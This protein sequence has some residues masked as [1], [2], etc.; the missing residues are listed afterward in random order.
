MVDNVFCIK[1]GYKNGIWYRVLA[2]AKVRSMFVEM[3]GR[4]VL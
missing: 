3:T 1:M 4:A 2:N